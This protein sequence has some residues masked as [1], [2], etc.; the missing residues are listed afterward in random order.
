MKIIGRVLL[1]LAITAALCTGIF[2]IVNGNQAQVGYEP[3]SGEFQQIESST[4]LLHGSGQG[5]RDG[6]GLQ[7]NKSLESESGEFQSSQWVNVLKNVGIFA[8][9]II[10]VGGVRLAARLIKHKRTMLIPVE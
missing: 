1:V 7:R 6:T 2:F 9:A 8:A 4:S 10:A 3:G 5:L